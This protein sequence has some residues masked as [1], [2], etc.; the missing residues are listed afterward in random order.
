MYCSM[1]HCLFTPLL[2]IIAPQISLGKSP[3]LHSQSRPHLTG[4]TWP[5]TQSIKMQCPLGH[6]ILFSDGWA[7]V[8]NQ[9]NESLPCQKK[10]PSLH[11]VVECQVGADGS[12]L[13]TSVWKPTK[14][15]IQIRGEQSRDMERDS[16][17]M[18]SY[19]LL[20]PAEPEVKGPWI[21]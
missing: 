9:P 11:G 20:D 15:W 13:A 3:P 21:F 7:Q 6:D 2:L 8:P 17:W 4:S 5:E 14:E 16:T 1:I 19:K 10:W 18:I 12:Y